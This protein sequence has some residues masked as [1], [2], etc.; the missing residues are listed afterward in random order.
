EAREGLARLSYCRDVDLAHRAWRENDVTRADLLL[1]RCP[2]SLRGWEW[3]YVRRLCHA[4]FC[5]FR[6]HPVN[7]TS[8]AF[9]P[10]GGRL[11]SASW[12]GTVKVWDARTGQEI[13][14]L[15]GGHSGPIRG[16]AFGPDGGRLATASVDGTVKVWDAQTG[17]EIHTLTG[18]TNQVWGVAFSP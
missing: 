14:T 4:D 5:T 18:H 2:M 9:G 10:D 13:R 3:Y 16:V 15:R 11:A 6:G 17:R 8:V 7:V 1:Q 12:D